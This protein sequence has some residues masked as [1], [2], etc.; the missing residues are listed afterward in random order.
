MRK[1]LDIRQVVLNQLNVVVDDCCQGLEDILLHLGVTLSFAKEESVGNRLY[2]SGVTCDDSSTCIF[3]RF[4]K[5]CLD[6]IILTEES[7]LDGVD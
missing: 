2:L 4:G 7:L 1:H 3:N 5:G 6:G